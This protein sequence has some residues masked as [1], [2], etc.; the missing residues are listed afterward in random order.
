[1]RI[2]IKYIVFDFKNVV[3]N[4]YKNQITFII[5]KLKNVKFRKKDQRLIEN[6]SKIVFFKNK[7]M[8]NLNIRSTLLSDK[9][10]TTLFKKSLVN[11]FNTFTSSFQIVRFILF[12][13]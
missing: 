10:V 3:N 12:L 1:M 4:D 9:K 13:Q 7:Y 6:V 2:I 5:A 8:L 11:V